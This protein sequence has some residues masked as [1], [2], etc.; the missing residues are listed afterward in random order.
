LSQDKL[1]RALGNT[2]KNNFNLSQM[3]LSKYIIGAAV[4]I[5]ILI[6]AYK[7]NDS[8]RD[9]GQVDEHKKE[10]A[11]WKASAETYLRAKDSLKLVVEQ[12]ESKDVVRVQTITA[13][14]A[15]IKRLRGRLS[16]AKD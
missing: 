9:Q 10:I 16:D 7:C 2:S 4:L 12:L 1:K 13:K 15:E 6:T 5:A 14:E 11:R 3:K 8:D